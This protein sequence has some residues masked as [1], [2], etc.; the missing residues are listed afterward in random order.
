MANGGVMEMTIEVHDIVVN[1][2]LAELQQ[3]QAASFGGGMMR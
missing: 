1:A 3:L 2:D